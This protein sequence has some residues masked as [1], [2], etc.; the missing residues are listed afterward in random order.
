M[1]FVDFIKT[2]GE[3]EKQN[4]R[5]RILETTSMNK[6]KLNSRNDDT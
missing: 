2:K 4:T 3:R 6:I 5:T 1:H